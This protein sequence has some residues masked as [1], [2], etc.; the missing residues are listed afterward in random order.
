MNQKGIALSGPVDAGA[1]LEVARSVVERRKYLWEETGPLSARAHQGGRKTEKKSSTKLVLGIELHGDELVL[2][3][4]THG[5]A[6]FLANLG[7]L[8]AMQVTGEFQ[9]MH[10]K[11]RRAVT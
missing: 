8:G 3:P 6:G 1:V 11:I 10:R 2:R 4:E 5:A 7:P 9:T